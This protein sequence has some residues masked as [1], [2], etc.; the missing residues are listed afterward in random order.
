MDEGVGIWEK[1][2]NTDS[3]KSTIFH[4]VFQECCFI[5]P[6]FFGFCRF[7]NGQTATGRLTTDANGNQMFSCVNLL[8]TDFERE[9]E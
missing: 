4:V 7:L 2:L 6:S 5:V 3:S 9:T 8:Q 1:D